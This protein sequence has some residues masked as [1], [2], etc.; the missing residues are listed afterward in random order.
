MMTFIPAFAKGLS[1]EWL[2]Q[3]WNTV[4]WYE[5]VTTHTILLVEFCALGICISVANGALNVCPFC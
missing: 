4:C 3:Y 5:S 2:V 1:P